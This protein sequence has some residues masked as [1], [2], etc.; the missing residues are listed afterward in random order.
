MYRRVQNTCVDCFDAFVEHWSGLI[1]YKKNKTG[2]QTAIKKKET[3][4]KPS[5]RKSGHV[6]WSK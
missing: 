1:E 5:F 4:Q 3:K 6:P 2:D